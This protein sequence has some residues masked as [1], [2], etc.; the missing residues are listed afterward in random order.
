MSTPITERTVYSDL[1]TNFKVHPVTNKLLKKTNVEA[2]KQS[3]RNLIQTNKGERLFQPDLGGDVRKMLFE[4]F[5][6]HTIITTQEI[7]KETVRSHEPRADLIAVNI[8]QT[9][10]EHEIQIQIVFR[11]VNVQDPVT[12]EIILERVR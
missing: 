11:V 6:P 10:D 4:N 7:I 2:V 1:F 3:I 8:T 9:L 12:L 5:T